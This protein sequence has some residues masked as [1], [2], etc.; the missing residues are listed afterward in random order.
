MRG[1]LHAGA[2][3]ASALKPVVPPNIIFMR[4]CMARQQR[5]LACLFT[6]NHTA[7]MRLPDGK[8]LPML[9]QHEG[10]GEGDVLPVAAVLLLLDAVPKLLLFLLLLVFTV[11]VT[12]WT[13]RLYQ[14]QRHP[15]DGAMLSPPAAQLRAVQLEEDETLLRRRSSSMSPSSRSPPRMPM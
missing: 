8:R 6:R 4:T 2:I 9:D 13:C 12:T 10:D 3:V 7:E 14:R 1:L 15:W 5:R 11:A